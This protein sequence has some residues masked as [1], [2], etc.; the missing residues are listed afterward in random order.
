[1]KTKVGIYEYEKGWGSRLEDTKEFDTLEQAKEFCLDYNKDLGK[2]NA[3]KGLN[4]KVVP[5]YF[6]RAEIIG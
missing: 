3:A 5:D 2:G 4:N 1:M 6:W